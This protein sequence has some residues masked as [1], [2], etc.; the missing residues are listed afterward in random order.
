MKKNILLL[1]ALIHWMQVSGQKNIRSIAFYNVENLYD[2]INDPAVDDEEFLPQGKNAWTSERYQR[3]LNNLARVID[4]LG[5]GPALLG[6]CEV[7][8]EGVLN[9]LIQHRLLIGKGYGIVHRNSPDKR[10]IDVALLYR[11]AD[12]SPE[13]VSSLTVKLPGDSAYPTRDILLVSGKLLG[14]PMHIFVN[15]WPSRRGGEQESAGKR[16]AAAMVAGKAVDSLLKNNRNACIVL[17]GDFNDQPG[18]ASLLTGLRAE[19]PSGKSDLLNLSAALAEKGEGTHSYKE[20]WNM[21]DNL[22]VSRSMAGKT[23]GL[24]LVPGSAEIYRPVWLQ[25]KY[26]RHAGAP[27][28]TFAGSKFIGGYSDHF[29]VFFKLSCP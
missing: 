16:M 28:R 6:L 5:G 13:A 24:A 11:K 19:G 4:S 26:S 15:H 14:N 3:K 2:T 27:Y 25:D 9:D 12:F 29:P 22:I 17:V 10:G 7:E 20:A 18:D 23:K 8:N 21:L 1:F